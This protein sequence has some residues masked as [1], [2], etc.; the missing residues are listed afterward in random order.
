MLL[1]TLI[2]LLITIDKMLML[3]ITDAVNNRC[4]SFQL[5]LLI[6]DAVNNINNAVNNINNAVNNN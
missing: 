5:M 2:M 4:R 6:T 1:I 3:L